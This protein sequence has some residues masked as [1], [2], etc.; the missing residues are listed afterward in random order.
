MMI[1][2]EYG[3]VVSP[4]QLAGSIRGYVGLE[5]GETT[6]NHRRLPQLFVA[7]NAENP[8]AHA[9]QMMRD[10]LV[11]GASLIPMYRDIGGVS[12]EEAERTGLARKYADLERLPD[13]AAMALGLEV[14]AYADV[15]DADKHAEASGYYGQVVT[16]YV[17]HADPG[18]ASASRS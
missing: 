11:A 12:V 8:E 6:A 17:V 5:L 10:T 3:K 1:E 9:G 14:P 13:E 16:D 18:I 7:L 2:P 15:W 4:T